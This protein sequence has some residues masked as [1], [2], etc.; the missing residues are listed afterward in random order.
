LPNVLCCGGSWMVTRDLVLSGEWD[1][2]ETLARDAM[3][4]EDS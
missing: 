1:T 3:S 4:I 2:I